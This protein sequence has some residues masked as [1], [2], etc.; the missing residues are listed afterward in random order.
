MRPEL[1]RASIFPVWVCS[2]HGKRTALEWCRNNGPLFLADSSEVKDP[3]VISG[4]RG[5]FKEYFLGLIHAT[6]L[7]RSSMLM[8]PRILK[9]WSDCFSSVFQ[10]KRNSLAWLS[11]VFFHRLDLTWSEKNVKCRKEGHS[12]L[13]RF[14]NSARFSLVHTFLAV[15]FGF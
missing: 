4:T 10:K 2:S 15:I 6:K 11:F 3:V 12:S 14:G 1:K 8:P 9:V 5:Y 13:S 7:R